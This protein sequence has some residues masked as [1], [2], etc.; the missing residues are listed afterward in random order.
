MSRVRCFYL[1]LVEPV[2]TRRWLRRYGSGP[3]PLLPGQHSCHDGRV[4]L[5]DFAGEVNE[6]REMP[7]KNDP[8]WPEAC[9]CGYRFVELDNHQLFTNHLFRRTDTGE[10]MTLREAPAGAIW[11]ASWMAGSPSFCGPDGR[12]LVCRLPGG[13]DWLIDSRASNCTMKDDSV[14]KCWV[15]HGEPPE[16]TVDKNGFTCQA[17]AGSILSSDGKYHGFLRNGY[18]EEC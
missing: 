6:V 5:G 8:R 7:E 4:L 13:H 15:R 9:G 17:G 16:L 12:S 14:H 3:C 2:Q 1:E 18:L 11:N 10:L